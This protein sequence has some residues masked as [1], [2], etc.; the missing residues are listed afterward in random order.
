MKKLGRYI[1]GLAIVAVAAI[2]ISAILVT[3]IAGIKKMVGLCS[4]QQVRG[5]QISDIAGMQE[6]VQVWCPQ[7]QIVLRSPTTGQWIL[8]K[9][10]SACAASCDPLAKYFVVSNGKCIWR[11]R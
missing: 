5:Q 8:Y 2:M 3:F 10:D 6:V 4:E 11:R 9:I 7:K 1:A